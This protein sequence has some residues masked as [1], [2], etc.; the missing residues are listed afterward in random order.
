MQTSAF[1]GALAEEGKINS[2]FVRRHRRFFFVAILRLGFREY[3]NGG[4]PVPD[5]GIEKNR[6]YQA[7]VRGFR[8]RLGIA[9]IVA[10]IENI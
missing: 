10:A 5:D 7:S 2:F 9:Y 8:S 4:S 6:I 3:P 1:L